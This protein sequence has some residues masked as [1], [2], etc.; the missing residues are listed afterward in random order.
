MERAPLSAPLGTMLT[1]TEEKERL[2]LLL[3]FPAYLFLTSMV[4]GV[5]AVLCSDLRLVLR[6][7]YSDSGTWP[8]LQRMIGSE[9][10]TQC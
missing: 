4:I 2:F 7:E 8:R 10:E 5:D 6:G 9:G 3:L 1:W